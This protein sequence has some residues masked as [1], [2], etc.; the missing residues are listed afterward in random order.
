MNYNINK[1]FQL[2]LKSHLVSND[3]RRVFK[4]YIKLKVKA[5]KKNTTSEKI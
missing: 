2:M 1:N 5:K 3:H 4:K